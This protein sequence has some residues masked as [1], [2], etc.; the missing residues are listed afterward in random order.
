MT[1]RIRPLEIGDSELVVAWR[2]RRDVHEQ[3]FAREAPTLE[4]HRAWY[5]AYRRSSDRE[6]LIVLKDERPVGTVGLSSID[7]HHRRAEFGILIGEPSA[8]GRGVAEAASRLLLER[9]FADLQL[10]RLWLHVF[11]ENAAALRLYERLG[12]HRE[13]LLRKHIIKDGVPRDIVVMG[14]LA[15]ERTPKA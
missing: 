5:E 4:S 8:R 2:N 11:P 7:R 15:S 1:V 13:G 14:L 10:L 6:E 3:L 9:A 12:F